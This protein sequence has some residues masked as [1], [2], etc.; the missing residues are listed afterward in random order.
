[1]P[2]V[3]EVPVLVRSHHPTVGPAAAASAT[4][5]AGRG[6]GAAAGAAVA[7]DQTHHVQDKA[8]KLSV[9]N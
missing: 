7:A 6:T 4:A 5:A 3:H 9:I 2:L 8:A 1:M